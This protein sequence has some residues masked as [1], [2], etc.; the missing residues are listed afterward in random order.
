MTHTHTTTVRPDP[1]QR[2]AT[3]RL[4]L[5]T[6]FWGISFPIMK[7]IGLIQQ[8]LLPESST[9][10]V[11][12][13]TM[14]GRFGAAALIMLAFSARTL[15]KSTWPEIWQGLGLGFF[16]GLGMLFQMDGLAYTSASSSAFLTQSYCL[17]LPIIVALRDRR[18]PS[19]LILFC[20]VLV[21]AGVAILAGVSWNKVRLGRGELE[22]K[23]ARCAVIRDCDVH[24]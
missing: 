5:A 15:R 6:L 16:A 7:A 11:S 12:A 14:V 2:K 23:L 18:R 8:K 17:L 20:S 21:I 13:N 19:P 9:W 24:L 1:I 3:E 4:I 10:F 22:T